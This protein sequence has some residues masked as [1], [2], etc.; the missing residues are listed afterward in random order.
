MKP[1]GMLVGTF[2]KY[3]LFVDKGEVACEQLD[4]EGSHAS[5]VANEF[6]TLKI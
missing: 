5:N 4:W 2:M 1:K 6:E 3:C